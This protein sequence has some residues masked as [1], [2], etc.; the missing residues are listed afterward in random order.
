MQ[1]IPSIQNLLLYHFIL[2]SIILC[3][4]IKYAR[5]RPGPPVRDTTLLDVFIISISIMKN[6]TVI[7][8]HRYLVLLRLSP[9]VSKRIR[10]KDNYGKT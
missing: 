5:Y 3:D 4:L 6:S 1:C 8:V 2:F 9:S 10:G 7:G